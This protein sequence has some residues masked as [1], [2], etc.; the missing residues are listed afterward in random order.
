MNVLAP[1][2]ITLATLF[3]LPA[4]HGHAAADA[5]NAAGST[6]DS[7]PSPI[8]PLIAI[9]AFAGKPGFT[10]PVLS[11][12][13]Q[14]VAARMRNGGEEMLLLH[15][16]FSTGAAPAPPQYIRLGRATLNWLEWASDRYLVG[17]L[18]LTRITSSGGEVAADRLIL[19]DREHPDQVKYLGPERADPNGDDVIF[20][21]P[22]GSYILLSVAKSIF[23]WPRVV[24]VD[25]PSNTITE[26]QH[27][28]IPIYFWSANSS[29]E[30][31]A[32]MG[33]SY[34]GLRVIYRAGASDR[35]E[36]VLRL[37]GN[38]EDPEPLYIVH[39]AADTQTGYVVSRRGGDRWGLHEYDFK[40]R[41]F[42]TPLFSHDKVD[43]DNLELDRQGRLR[44]VSFVDDRWR[45][46]WF[47]EEEKLFYG[48]L[49]KAVPDRMAF[50]NSASASKEIKIIRTEAPT[51]PGTFYVYTTGSG[52]MRL[53]AHVNDELRGK[54]LAP[55]QHVSYP[56]RDGLQIP[57]YLTLPVGRADTRLP[58]IVMPHGGPF[59]RDRWGFDFLAQYLA[60]RGYAVLQPNFRGST[61]YGKAFEERGYGQFGKAMQDDVD[62]GVKWLVDKGQVDPARVCVVGWSYGG[63]VAQVASFRNP[64][65][66]RCAVSIAGISDLPAMIRYDRRFMYGTTYRK[67]RDRI[68]GDSSR[69]A[70]SD[71]SPLSQI[72]SIAVPLLLVHGTEDHNVPV[73]QSDRLAREL[74]QA[75]N[76]PFSYV[77][78]E[79]GDHSLS[80]VKQREQLLRALETFLAAHNPTDVLGNL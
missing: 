34:D 76:R 15:R 57:G 21:A 49:E 50:V 20:W 45:M 56:A 46:Q 22:D 39:I 2:L 38:D 47:Q 35:F 73:S 65:T 40:S 58:L 11:P 60:N 80:D 48:D 25:I 24:R 29:G 13:G 66:Y 44:W 5:G 54:R 26:V 7:A 42:G 30:V 4:L 67:W 74:K 55:V 59:H 41:T 53:L 19:V 3:L 28:K 79:D 27:E 6:D 14:V 33:F 69:R 18:R 51:D 75:G 71:V 70:L 32:G 36:T 17:S 72:R 23:S 52:K 77:R 62:D 78:I 61:G 9:S 12:D 16:L 68:Q 43:L 63:Y 1:A 10:D 31:V 37:R 64:E 8:P